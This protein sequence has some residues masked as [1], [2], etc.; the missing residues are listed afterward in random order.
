MLEESDY[1]SYSIAA[2][3]VATHFLL[4]IHAGLP[5]PLR[6]CVPAD[7]DDDDAPPAALLVMGIESTSSPSSLAASRSIS[8]SSISPDDDDDEEE[9]DDDVEVEWDDVCFAPPFLA[10]WLIAVGSSTYWKGT[11]FRIISG[12][13]N[14]SPRTG[15]AAVCICNCTPWYVTGSF[16]FWSSCSLKVTAGT[17]PNDLSETKAVGPR[18]GGRCEADLAGSMR[19]RER[20]STC[21][22][23]N[24]KSN[25]GFDDD[26]PLLLVLPVLLEL[27]GRSVDSTKS[28]IFVKGSLG[29][30]VPCNIVLSPENSTRIIVRAYIGLLRAAIAS[31]SALDTKRP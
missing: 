25:D 19:P 24:H 16:V 12:L 9:E 26:A 21:E 2:I 11:R 29:A 1:S 10:S 6:P 4:I 20:V 31:A 30:N 15:T 14:K 23:V 13:I 17:K 7:D 28:K 18:I 3:H 8:A 27:T 5:V 22:G